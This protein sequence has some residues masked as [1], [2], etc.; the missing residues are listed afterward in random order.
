MNQLPREAY[1]K[2]DLAS[3]LGVCEKTIDGWIA[4]GDGPPYFRRART[5]LFPAETLKEWM[6]KQCHQQTNTGKEYHQDLGYID[7]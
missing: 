6:R 3:V 5:I 4:K 1:R 7:E 2:N